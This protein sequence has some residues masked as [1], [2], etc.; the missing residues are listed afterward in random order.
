[1]VDV[2]DD[3]THAGLAVVRLCEQAHDVSEVPCIREPERSRILADYTVEMPE[4]L[5]SALMAALMSEGGRR[6]EQSERCRSG[7]DH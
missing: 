6:R 4:L 5:A 3:V 2:L 1:V 7:S